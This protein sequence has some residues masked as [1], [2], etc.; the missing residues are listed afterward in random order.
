MS[1]GIKAV[2]PAE[3]SLD[4]FPDRTIIGRMDEISLN[5]VFVD[6]HARRTPFDQ[7]VRHCINSCRVGAEREL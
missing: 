5:L 7:K 1:A 2:D 3:K 4:V 6:N